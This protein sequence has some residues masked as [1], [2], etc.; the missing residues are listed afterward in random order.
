MKF[1][2]DKENNIVGI[3]DNIQNV[4]EWDINKN[5]YSIIS[6]EDDYMIPNKNLEWVVDKSLIINRLDEIDREFGHRHIR[7]FILLNSH[8]CDTVAY[9]KIQQA[10]NEAITLRGKLC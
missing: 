5:E 8:M 10:E 6:N 1:Q 3:F 9:N 2:I 4:E 7:D